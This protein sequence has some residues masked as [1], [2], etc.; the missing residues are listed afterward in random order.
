MI[1]IQSFV[2]S[3]F[4]E[5][6]Y[7][8]FDETH[9][10]VIIDPGCL[11]Q[12]EKETL[13]QFITQNRLIV[14]ALLQTHAHLDHVFGSAFVK[15]KYGVKM[16]MHKNELPI[17]ASVENRCQLWGI[18]GYEP[19]E[20]DEF[21]DEGD[22]ISFGNS[23][24]EILFVPGHAPGHLAFVNHAQRFVIGGDVLFKGSIGRTDFPLCDHDALINSI[25]TKFMTLE[26]DYRVYA[27][28]MDSTTIGHERRTNPF[29]T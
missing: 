28:H 17:L 26:D 21:I 5:N 12:A 8:L 11:M 7:I 25:Q 20:A 4:Q 22:I 19:V 10:A 3:P 6:T 16:W 18:R 27:G 24:L 1:Q 15:R 29:L 9:E 14:K 23:Q 2:F 13:A